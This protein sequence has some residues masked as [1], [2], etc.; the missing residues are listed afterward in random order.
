MEFYDINL[1]ISFKNDVR[2]EAPISA[3]I[4]F[5]TS[6]TEKMSMVQKK[7]IFGHLNINS[8]RKMFEELTI[9]YRQQYRLTSDI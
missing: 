2:H 8:V 7:A 9:H 3:L 5:H 6:A 4:V 1:D